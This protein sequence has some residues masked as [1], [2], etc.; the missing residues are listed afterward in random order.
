M[1]AFT[2][3]LTW[4][5]LAVSLD[6]SIQAPTDPVSRP[7]AAVNDLQLTIAPSTARSAQAPHIDFDIALR[8]T[9]D[10]EL[11]L[12]LGTI[13]GRVVQ[14]DAIRLILTE[15][16]GE[17]HEL[18]YFSRAAGVAGRIDDYIVALRAGS[19]Y[20]VRISLADY[21]RSATGDTNAKLPNGHY[22]IAAQLAGRLATHHNFDTRPAVLRNLWSGVAYSN[23]AE[24]DLSR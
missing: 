1:N 21:C 16:G 20:T 2:C 6:P 7:G 9:G 11:E 22:K 8:N 12:N 15:P 10:S 23:I 24:F 5:A 19:V 13:V 17:I 3:C 18:Q 14:P 4:I